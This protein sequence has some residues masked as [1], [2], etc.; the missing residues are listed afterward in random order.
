MIGSIGGTMGLCIGFSF[1]NLSG[2]F[3]NLVETV[4]NK[5]TSKQ[6]CSDLSTKDTSLDYRIEII[7]DKFVTLEQKMDARFCK[8]EKLLL[9]NGGDFPD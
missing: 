4:I 3:I 1:A 5:V 7:E 8:I 2:C 6:R 9:N